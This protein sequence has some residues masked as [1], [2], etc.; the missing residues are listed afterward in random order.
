MPPLRGHETG[1][2]HFGTARTRSFGVDAAIMHIQRHER[3]IHIVCAA[4]GPV[5]AVSDRYQ[6]S[7]QSIRALPQQR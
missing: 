5:S 6:Q 2:S 1:T 7:R 3:G 4:V